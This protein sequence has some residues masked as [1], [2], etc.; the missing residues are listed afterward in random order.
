MR[1]YKAEPLSR[2]Q[3][4]MLVREIRKKLGIHD[5]KM[6]DVIKLLEN[7]LPILY[8]E[9]FSY[10]IVPDEEL[11]VMALTTPNEGKILIRESVYIGA[12]EGSGRDRFTVMHEIAHF[13]LHR[14]MTVRLARGT[15]EI[16][17]FEDPEW[18]ADAFAGEFL[19][20]YDVAKDME[21]PEMVLKCGVSVAAARCQYKLYQKVKKIG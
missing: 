6:V 17:P 14:G 11:D 3:I 4:R 9:D 7:I 8:G 18:Q 10:E 13:F 19:M 1:C 2:R 21:I 15:E 20:A 5:K 12:Y 16:H